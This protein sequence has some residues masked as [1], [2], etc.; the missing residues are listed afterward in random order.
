MKSRILTLLLG[1]VL[2]ERIAFATWDTDPRGGRT[3]YAPELHARTHRKGANDYLPHFLSEDEELG[4]PGAVGDT[5]VSATLDGRPQW[6]PYSLVV[7]AA[8]VRN[9]FAVDNAETTPTWKATLDA[10]A[11]TTIAEGDAAA[12]GTSLIYSHRDHKHGAPATYKATSHN[13]LDGDRHGDTAAGTVAR[14]DLVTGQSATPKWTRLAKPSLPSSLINNATDVSWN[15][16]TSVRA[17]PQASGALTVNQATQTV[18][19]FNAE[20]WDTNAQ[21][22][23]GSNTSRL[24]CVLAGRYH[25]TGTLFWNAEIVSTTTLLAATIFKNGAALDLRKYD[26]PNLAMATYGHFLQVSGDVELAV[27]DYLELAAFYDVN[28]ATTRTLGLALCSFS[29]FWV[30]P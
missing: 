15:A 29:M 20:S 17:G 8:N 2:T 21:H 12:A 11:P 23:T 4:P 22:D 19:T 7:P 30:G 27:N 14:G 16:F 3:D 13:L 18:V 10:T 9:A 1:L 6:R 5:I 28:A 26:F 25:V 24:T